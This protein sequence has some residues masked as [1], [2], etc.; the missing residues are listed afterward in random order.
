M[1][2]ASLPSKQYGSWAMAQ[3]LRLTARDTIFD[4]LAGGMSRCQMP[5]HEA[6]MVLIADPISV[7]TPNPPGCGG[8]GIAD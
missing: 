1:K 8:P 2:N 3:S 4:A 6:L 7:E 5:H